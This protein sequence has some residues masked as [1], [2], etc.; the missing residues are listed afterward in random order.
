M[1]NY[2]DIINL[3][4]PK[5]N[6]SHLGIDSRAAQ[7]APFAA[8]TG[9][10][11]QVKETA[12]LTDRRIDIDE[13]LRDLLNKKINYIEMNLKDKPSVSFT[14]FIPD[15]TKDGGKYITTT[16]IVKR[17]DSVNGI[18][19]LTNNTIIQMSEIINIFGEL[20]KGMQFED[21]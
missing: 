3:S 16:G 13:E 8:L 20:F 17:I 4:R 21:Y 1:N 14:Y 5:S 6:H 18:I 7:F 12:R 11:D 9:Y 15:E 2:D 10:D 19:K